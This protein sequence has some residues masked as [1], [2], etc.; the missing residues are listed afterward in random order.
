M[1]KEK[2]EELGKLY[3]KRINLVEIKCLLENPLIS[4]HCDF[5][6]REKAIDINGEIKDDLISFFDNKIK[7]LEEH[8]SEL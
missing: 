6:F 8:I 5:T 1:T 2:F 4:I 7:E 3:N